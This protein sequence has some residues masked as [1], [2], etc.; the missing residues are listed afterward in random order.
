MSQIHGK[1]IARETAVQSLY[2]YTVSQKEELILNY[3]S[4][5]KIANEFINLTI[6]N[7]NHC[8]EVISKNLKKWT[9]GEISMINLCILRLLITEYELQNTPPGI[10][11]KE[12]RSLVN[13]L[14]DPKD[15]KFIHSILS[16]VFN[17]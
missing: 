8:D 15:E 5:D 4:N 13:K 7:I 11:V 6:K 3:E 10:L 17:D 16:K 12:S 14:S 9:I 1:T 2:T